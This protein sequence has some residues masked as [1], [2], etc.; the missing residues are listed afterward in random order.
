MKLEKAETATVGHA[1]RIPGMTQAAIT[2]ILITM[3]KM[4]MEA[5]APQKKHHSEW[6]DM[7]DIF[8]Y[9]KCQMPLCA[10]AQRGIRFKTDKKSDYADRIFSASFR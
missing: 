7:S 2:A 3:K 9:F 4:D 1:E 5:A 10:T 6:R 8:S